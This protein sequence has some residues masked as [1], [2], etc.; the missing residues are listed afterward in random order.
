[1]LLKKT[2]KNL[3]SNNKTA[4]VSLAARWV[5]KKVVHW[6]NLPVQTPRAVLQSASRKKMY[7][8]ERDMKATMAKFRRHVSNLN[9]YLDTVQI[10]MSSHRF[11]EIEFDKL[12]GRATVKF[13]KAWKGVDKTGKFIHESDTDRVKCCEKLY[14]IP[15]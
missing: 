10:K 4:D 12:P 15:D 11:S 13:Q 1:M 3:M 6:L 5:L 14:V 2:L 9:K 8:H 7:P